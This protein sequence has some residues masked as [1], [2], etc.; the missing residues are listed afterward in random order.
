ML[1]YAYVL[2]TNYIPTHPADVYLCPPDECKSNF[3]SPFMKK[4]IVLANMLADSLHIQPHR[5]F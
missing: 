5:A 4:K 3:Y 2:A 1:S